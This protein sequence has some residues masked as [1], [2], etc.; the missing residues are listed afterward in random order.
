MTPNAIVNELI[1]TNHPKVLRAIAPLQDAAQRLGIESARTLLQVVM[2]PK[3]LDPQRKYTPAQRR[4]VWERDLHLCAYCAEEM[5]FGKHVHADHVV[6]WS[7][8]GRTVVANAVCACAACNI[9]KKDKLIFVSKK[10]N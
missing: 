1:R 3:G 9:G 6:P 7:L 10:G 8:G 4:E 2:M 5:E